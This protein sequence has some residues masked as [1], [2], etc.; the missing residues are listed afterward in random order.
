MKTTITTESGRTRVL[1]AH[2]DADTVV[3]LD[4]AGR[5]VV[6]EDWMGGGFFALTLCCD[7]W[8]KGTESGICCRACY[9]DECG[10]YPSESEIDKTVKTVK[11]N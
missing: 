9:G 6:Q 2:V 1:P 11:E 10:D 7:A 8:D 5:I 4:R 3:G